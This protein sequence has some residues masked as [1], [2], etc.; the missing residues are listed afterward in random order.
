[1]GDRVTLTDSAS[2]HDRDY[3]ITG[4]SHQVDARARQHR[5]TWTLKP[6]DR[7]LLFLLDASP[8]NSA[9]ILAL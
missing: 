6:A 9:H 1:I 3:L 5:L 7:D 4:E 2:G 8:L